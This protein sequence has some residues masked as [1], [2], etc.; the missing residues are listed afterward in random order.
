MFSAGKKLREMREQIGL[1]LR[2]VEISSTALAQARGIDEFVIN[3]SRLSDIET[4]G[5]VPSIY[6][7]YVLSVVY[8]AAFTEL[9][10]LYGVDLSDVVSDLSISR[11]AKTHRIATAG[12]SG[13]VRMPVKLDPSFDPRTTANLGRMIEHWGVVP[14]QYLNELSKRRYTYAYIGTEDLTMYPLLLPGSF[15]QVD[16]SRNQV[17]GGVWRSEYERPMY[18]IET[19]EG[20]VCC[21]CALHPQRKGEIVLQPH[22]LAPVVPRIL[23]H[24]SEA[25]VLGQVVGIAM[26]LEG[27][28]S[29]RGPERPRS[30]ESGE[31]GPKEDR[32]P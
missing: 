19:R 4:K 22:P 5:L 11:P 3:P 28:N 13:E 10:K 14:L 18:F 31:D 23:K 6:R 25:E 16:E 7:L 12:Q 15:V 8:R 29:P 24:G 2:D 1:T 17:E 32:R 20:Y 30:P 26:R 21:W 9:I 27:W